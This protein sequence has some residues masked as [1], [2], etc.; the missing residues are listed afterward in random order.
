MIPTPEHL[1][2]VFTDA[3]ED[4]HARQPATTPDLLGQQIIAGIAAVRDAVLEGTAQAI[5]DRGYWVA[6]G[7]WEEDT[8]VSS[9]IADLIRAMKGNQP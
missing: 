9:G 3:L 4:T 7:D 8:D 6:Q 2:V 5:A 1:A